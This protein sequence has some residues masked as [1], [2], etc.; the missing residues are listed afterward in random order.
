MTHDGRI[1]WVDAAKG[2]CIILVVMMHSTLGVGIAMGGDGWLHAAVAFAEPFRVPAFFLLAGLFAHRALTWSWRRFADRRILH[3]AYFYVLWVTIQFAFK[4]PGIAADIGALGALQAYLL[5]FV[6]P[7]GTLW[8][9]YVLPVFYL[10]ARFAQPLPPALVLAV[11]LALHL[12]PVETGWLL[13][14]ETAQFLVFFL[15]GHLFRDQIFAL[16]KAVSDHAVLAIVL[17]AGWVPAHAW[18]QAQGD[19]VGVPTLLSAVGAMAMVATA[20][21]LAGR[22]P[23]NALID[24]LNWVGKYSIVVYLAFF[25]PMAVTRTLIVKTGLITDIG[26]ASLVT[27]VAAV[28]GPIMLYYATRLTGLGRFLFERPRL[29]IIE[30]RAKDRVPVPAE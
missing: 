25:L 9:I 23:R 26:L 27:T 18:L 1:E 6:Q 21:I 13:I 8:F 20:A 14:D 30:R 3:Y 11:A 24:G 2:I 29:A 5:A 16:A 4:A 15:A 7:F 28:A 17:L 12:L 22:L 10:I 19:L